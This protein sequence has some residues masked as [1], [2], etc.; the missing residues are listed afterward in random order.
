MK[1][2]GKEGLVGIDVT[3]PRDEAAVHDEFFDGDT[4]L[5]GLLVEEGSTTGAGQG[6][7]T[8]LRE[9]GTLGLR[10]IF[11]HKEMNCPKSPG[12]VKPQFGVIVEQP[13]D[14]IMF[15]GSRSC[16]KNTHIT[17]HSKVDCEG[18]PPVHSQDE[19]LG[20]ASHFGDCRGAQ[21]ILHGGTGD[22]RAESLS[23]TL[24]L[25]DGSPQ[26]MGAQSPTDHL[27]FGELRHDYWC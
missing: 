18:C 20:P 12:I 24:D 8:H 10:C 6:F 15:L 4:A 5:A 1:Q 16:R 14:V 23:R 21:F 11:G 3:Y 2:T 22:R 27:Y 17:G 19:I 13:A 9:E 26:E 7:G 25:Q